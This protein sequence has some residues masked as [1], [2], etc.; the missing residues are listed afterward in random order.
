LSLFEE[1]KP[2]R[3]RVDGAT[4]RKDF[5]QTI[6]NKGGDGEAQAQSTEK[7]TRTIF[8]CGTKQ[9]YEETQSKKG[10]RSTLP[11]DA[12]TAYIVGETAAT[13]D[14]KATDIDGNQQQ[15]NQQIVD[16]VEDSSKK[17]KGLFPWNW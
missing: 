9:L 6:Q 2:V 17:V 15:R 12:Q 11:Q 5:T 14:L 3:S 10:D 7:M 4:V 16:T 1:S 8:G 13:H